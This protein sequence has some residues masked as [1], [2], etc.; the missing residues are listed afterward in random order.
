MFSIKFG[1]SFEVSSQGGDF[2]IRFGRRE[3]FYERGEGWKR[4][5]VK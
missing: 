2:L 1:R 5:I 4:E 3:W